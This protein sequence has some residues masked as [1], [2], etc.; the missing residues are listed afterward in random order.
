MD[1]HTHFTLRPVRLIIKFKI[2]WNF[3]HCGLNIQFSIT[4]RYC[5][6]QQIDSW[7]LC[8]KL[9]GTREL[10][11]KPLPNCKLVSA[12]AQHKFDYTEQILRC[13][14]P[15]RAE[16]RP[17]RQD[18]YMAGARVLRVYNYPR[19]CHA[20]CIARKWWIWSKSRNIRGRTHGR[21]R[22]CSCAR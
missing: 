16:T 12:V 2:S 3:Y 22:L 4:L 21:V 11:P 15:S 20:R 10:F 7:P 8:V 6:L 14:I 9:F 18:Q 5:N 1:F 13:K 19:G 17:M